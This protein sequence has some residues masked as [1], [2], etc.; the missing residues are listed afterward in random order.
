MIWSI[1]FLN[2]GKIGLFGKGIYGFGFGDGGLGFLSIGL[3][4]F[5]SNIKVS[6]MTLSKFL[7]T[8]LSTGSLDFID[9]QIH[10]L[11]I[12]VKE[13]HQNY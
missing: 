5:R 10:N 12:F 6:I 2:Q 11:A 13:N 9:S 8:Q 4:R 7:N 3:K 1:F